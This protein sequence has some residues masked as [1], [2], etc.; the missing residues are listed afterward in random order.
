MEIAYPYSR[1]LTRKHGFIKGEPFDANTGI[2]SG[3]KRAREMEILRQ[4]LQSEL[5]AVRRLLHKAAAVLAP[6][7]SPSAPRVKE[8]RPGFLAEEP[9]AKK[10]KASPPVP[11]NSCK[12]APT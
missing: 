12:K 4:R 3:P 6:A 5:V 8:S 2:I 7:S 11:V 1:E 10:R 9:L